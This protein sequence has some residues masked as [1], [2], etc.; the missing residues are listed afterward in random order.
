MLPTAV[1]VLFAASALIAAPPPTV[2]FQD[3]FES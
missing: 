1:L 3:D 2:W